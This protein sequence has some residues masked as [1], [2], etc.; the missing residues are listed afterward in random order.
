MKM[1]RGIMEVKIPWFGPESEPME[2]VSWLISPGDAVEI[3]QDIAM[4]QIGDET[5]PFPSPIDGKVCTL[6]VEPGDHLESGMVLATVM[7]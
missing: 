4:V 1:T 5:L 6:E 2:L 7:I 3:D